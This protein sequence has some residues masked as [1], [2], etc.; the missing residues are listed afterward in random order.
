METTQVVYD[1]GMEIEPN[2]IWPEYPFEAR[3]SGIADRRKEIRESLKPGR[4]STDCTTTCQCEE[5]PLLLK[6]FHNR[7]QIAEDAKRARRNLLVECPKCNIEHATNFHPVRPGLTL[8][9]NPQ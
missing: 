7:Y 6:D 1:I 8:M 9:D 2:T 4:R 5:K 3:I